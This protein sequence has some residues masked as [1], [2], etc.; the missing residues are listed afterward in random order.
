MN[1]VVR[2]ALQ[3]A[4]I[5]S[6]LEPPGLDRGDGSRPDGI[7]FFPFSRGSIVS[8]LCGHLCLVPSEVQLSEVEN[9]L[10]EVENKVN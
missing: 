10:I 9:N 3:R 2:R 4:G 5:P 1:D 8:H 6:V 7:T